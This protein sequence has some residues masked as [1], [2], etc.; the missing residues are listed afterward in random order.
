M[1]TEPTPFRTVWVTL[2]KL[3]ERLEEEASPETRELG[4]RLARNIAEAELEFQLLNRG[5]G[6]N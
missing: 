2:G 4:R 3:R 5:V 6:E 1:I